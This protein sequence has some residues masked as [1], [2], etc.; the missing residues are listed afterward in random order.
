MSQS[1]SELHAA[2]NNAAPIVEP[3]EL[4]APTP[5]DTPPVAVPPVDTPPAGTP[6][7]ATPPVDTPP[8]IVDGMDSFLS[9][10]GIG[11]SLI[12]LKGPDGEMQ[13]VAFNELDEATKYNVLTSLVK[14]V[15]DT[16]IPPEYRALMADIEAS[17][18]KPQDYINSQVEANTASKAELDKAMG[19]YDA[20]DYTALSPED[21]M[22]ISMVEADA[23]KSDEDIFAEIEELKKTSVYE[24]I[25]K[26][27]RDKFISTQASSV[28]DRKSEYLNKEAAASDES[29]IDLITAV[30]NMASVATFELND[31]MKEA[32]L[33]RILPT[34]ADG[35]STFME[36]MKDPAKLSEAAWLFDKGPGIIDSM[37]KYYEEKLATEVKAAY[38]EGKKFNMRGAP[39]GTQSTVQVGKT[40]PVVAPE[41]KKKMTLSDLHRK[42]E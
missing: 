18:K 21:I 41:G 19:D 31:T 16:S 7:D 1:L 15:D 40:P 13:S 6:P 29:K 14:N 34:L 12:D 3:V 37:E 30:D 32:I 26:T 38:A 28:A 27:V 36:D 8:V 25:V 24:S 5:V 33:G 4:D 11:E 2:S 20:T 10:F 22:F 23:S 39:A 17:G 42:K 35:T 9:D